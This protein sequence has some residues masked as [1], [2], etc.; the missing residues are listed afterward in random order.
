MKVHLRHQSAVSSQV[1]QDFLQFGNIQPG[2]EEHSPRSAQ[3]EQRALESSQPVDKIIFS[4][5][6]RSRSLFQKIEKRSLIGYRPDRVS[7]FCRA[8]LFKQST[9]NMVGRPAVGG[10]GGAA[11][12]APPPPPGWPAHHIA[13][14]LFKQASHLP[15]FIRDPFVWTVYAEIDIGDPLLV[16]TTNE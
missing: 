8:C 4:T 10:W 1:L 12:T 2:F 3:S 7:V 15:L 5:R 13:G 6:S 16:Q 9:C 14:G 11:R